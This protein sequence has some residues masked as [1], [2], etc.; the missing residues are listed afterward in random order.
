MDLELLEQLLHEPESQSLD[1]KQAQYR[2]AGASVPE[3]SELL[4]DVLAFANS[5]RRT[6]A[7]ILIGVQ[8]VKGGRGQVIGI[9]DHI[10][11]ASLQQFINSKTQRPVELSYEVVQLEG[12]KIGV[13][14]IPIQERPFYAKATYG[15][16]KSDI[17]YIRAG[18]STRE[19]TPEDLVQMGA[20]QSVEAVPRLLLSWADAGERRLLSSPYSADRVLLHPRLSSNTFDFAVRPR[21]F[22]DIFSFR[23]N[24]N[25]SKDLIEYCFQQALCVELGLAL[26]NESRSPA[27]R[28]RFVGSIPGSA[29]EM[30]EYLAPLPEREY[31]LVSRTAGLMLPTGD[32]VEPVVQRFRDRWEISVDFGDVRPRETVFTHSP[33]Y[34]RSVVSAAVEL[35]GLL[36]AD[37][38][39]EPVP[40]SLEVDLRVEQ[41]HMKPDDAFPYLKQ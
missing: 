31:D 23:V 7:Y 34:L 30:P 29:V 6:S 18:S 14:E 28:V 15:K 8:E 40:C 9:D 26:Y 4:K 39:P 3:K 25:Y 33:I 32:E 20:Q 19:A 24:S 12:V 27:K 35:R 1:F 41:R 13:I 17:V 21:P 36:F 22:P 5:W 10:E 16:V 37:N 11:D 38:L 2:F